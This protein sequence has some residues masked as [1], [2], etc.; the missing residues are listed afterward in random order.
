MLDGKIDSGTSREQLRAKARNKQKT[1]GKEPAAK[2]KKKLTSALEVIGERP[3]SRSSGDSKNSFKISPRLDGADI[4]MM[5]YALGGDL[6]NIV[7]FDVPSLNEFAPSVPKKTRN[8]AN[9][10][11]PKQKSALRLLGAE[12]STPAG[13]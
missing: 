3:E 4:E 12:V 11:T 2:S 7:A 8:N 13:L 9:T 6:N 10:V 1:Q 5:H